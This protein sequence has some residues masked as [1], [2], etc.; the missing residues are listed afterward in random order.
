MKTKEFCIYA[1]STG[2]HGG[3]CYLASKILGVPCITICPENSSE[4]KLGNM[5]KVLTDRVTEQT[6]WKVKLK[7][8]K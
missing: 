2:N 1:A 7:L 8:E 5:K 4:A 6:V 3:C